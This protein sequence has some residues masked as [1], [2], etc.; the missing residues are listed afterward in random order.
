MSTSNVRKSF[1]KYLKELNSNFEIT[2]KMNYTDL[3]ED[4]IN[5]CSL[6]RL[7]LNDTEMASILGVEKKHI[8]EMKK[9]LLS[10]MKL[11]EEQ[12]LLKLLR[13]F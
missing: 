6:I 7:K 10:K 4:E 1:R 2:L 9:S 3:T 5:L 13:S 12:K 11:K 8:D